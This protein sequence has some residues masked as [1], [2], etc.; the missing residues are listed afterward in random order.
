MAARRFWTEEERA[1]LERMAA[2]G[3]GARAVAAA[4]GRGL[5]GVLT[6][7]S[8]HGIRFDREAG[9]ARMATA[10][11]VRHADPAFQQKHSKACARSWTLERRAAQS[12]IAIENGNGARL[13]AALQLPEAQARRN[14]ANRARGE[15][16]LAWCPKDRLD[17][18]RCLMRTPG[19]RAAEAK[20][21]VLD[22]IAAKE[23]ARLAAMTPF[24][25][26]LERL[27]QGARLEERVYLTTPEH[28]FTL[29]GVS[30]GMA[31]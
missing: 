12:H 10:A 25:R 29:G 31:G 8:K 15:R 3:C 17:E 19:I 28:E 21:I 24:E 23:R 18:Y 7:A 4:L 16:Q 9:Y 14:A 20:R 6:Y 22:D 30:A 11:R 5:R 13:K 2:D 26:Q 1:L 27:R